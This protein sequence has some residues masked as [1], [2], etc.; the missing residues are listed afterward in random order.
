MANYDKF[1][2]ELYRNQNIGANDTQ[3]NLYSRKQYE[4]LLNDVKETLENNKDASIEEL[5]EDLFKKSQIEEALKDFVLNRKMTPGAVIS[6]GTENFQETLV[7]GNRQETEKKYGVF[8]PSFKSMH[9][10]TIF[11]LASCSKLFIALS[12]LKLVEMGLINLDDD[13]T[14][15]RPEF[16]EL[17]G[18]T[19]F[20]LLTFEPI[21]TK[22]RID[23]AK[24]KEEAEKILFTAE[25]KELPYGAN[26]YNDFAPMILKYAIEKASGMKYYD[27]LN[28]VIL[29]EL[30]MENTFVKVPEKKLENTANSNY[31]G[32][33]YKDG[34]FIIRTN[35]TPGISTDEKARI[36]GQPEGI[37]SGHAGLFSN[38][39]DM[40]KLSR[41]LID[42]K[43]LTDNDRN[44]MA[45]NQTGFKYR[46]EDGEQTYST[47][48]GMLCHSKSPIIERSEVH[49]P[50][51]GRTFAS[52][53][54]S[55]TQNTTD[56]LNKINFTLLSNRSHNRI[57]YVD[58]AQQD[59]GFITSDG[60]KR[61]F[62]PNGGTMIDSSRYAW[63]RDEI[64]HKC[65]DL[66]L[67]YKLLED[68]TGYRKSK[69]Q[70]YDETLRKIK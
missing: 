2:D 12:T 54:W 11:D 56:P 34:N 10:D 45:K 21:G 39:E 4:D 60:A 14:K 62:L 23:Q 52:A 6:Y 32:R 9:K 50:L 25:K 33:Y 29:K 46:N 65:I 67:K 49:H 15:Y 55:G 59:K 64:V 28:E 69:E 36:L 40:T 37:L 3:M 41:G 38:I 66:A 16:T 8:M 43:I 44:Y 58:K 30:N 53:G 19:I 18:V 31:D 27:F 42:G 1:V 24:S 22:E 20:D 47:Y 17:K 26:V 61:I 63:D 35:A 7:I 70:T 48:L 51:S 68:I 5:R 57:T 13:I